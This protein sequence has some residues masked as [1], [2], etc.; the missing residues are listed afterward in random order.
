MG[1]QYGSKE[2]FALKINTQPFE[3]FNYQLINGTDTA[4]FDPVMALE[5]T[6]PTLAITVKNNA[7]LKAINCFL[8]PGGKTRKNIINATTAHFQ[9]E[10]AHPPGR[11]RFNCTAPAGEGHYFWHSIPFIRRNSDDSW[12]KE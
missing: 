10:T 12:V 9:A 7:Q 6:Q 5:Q 1:G 11:S 2:D 8:S 4:T 3:V